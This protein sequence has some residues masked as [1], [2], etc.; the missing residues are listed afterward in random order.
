MFLDA[1]H[2]QYR[3]PQLVEVI[4]QLRFPAILSIG[5]KDPVDFQERIRREYPRYTRN[6]EKLPP[7]LM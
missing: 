3:K 4:C 5:A 2:V 1:S 6:I 7:K